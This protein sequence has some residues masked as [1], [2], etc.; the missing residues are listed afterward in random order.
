[1]KGIQMIIQVVFLFSLA[2]LG[3]F[4]QMWLQLPIPGAI[5]GFVL[6]LGLLLTKAI[7]EKWVE[8]GAKALLFILPLLFVPFNLGVMDYPELLSSSGALM[9]LSVAGSTIVSMI[10]IGHLCQWLENKREKELMK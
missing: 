9:V 1:M 5:I 2:W 6:L 10:A 8:Q 4:I 7:P 3:G